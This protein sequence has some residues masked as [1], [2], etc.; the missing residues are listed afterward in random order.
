MAVAKIDGYAVRA[1]ALICAAPVTPI[2]LNV[3]AAIA[4]GEETDIELKGNDCAR[5]EAGAVVPKGANS[6][7]AL[8]AVTCSGDGGVG[9][10]I[11][12][13]AMARF[14]DNMQ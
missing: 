3:I 13:S 2:T 14:N 9:D 6:V 1:E 10:T 8:D 5:V 11:A 7:I 4:A 12:A